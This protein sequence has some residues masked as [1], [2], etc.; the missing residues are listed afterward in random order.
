MNVVYVMG[1]EN[2]EPIFFKC[3]VARAFWYGSPFIIRKD[4]ME[5]E[6]VKEWIIAWLNT[7]VSNYQ[8]VT[9]FYTFLIA[10]MWYL[11]LHRN[12]MVFKGVDPNPRAILVTFNCYQWLIMEVQEAKNKEN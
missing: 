11:W 1:N 4:L 5:L 8:E 10:R 12:E 7:S 6:S 3:D 2:V 9:W